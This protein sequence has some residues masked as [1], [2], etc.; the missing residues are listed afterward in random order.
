VTV[1]TVVERAQAVGWARCGVKR[2]G[3]PWHLIEVDTLGDPRP[4]R[5]WTPCYG[6]PATE[7]APP[8]DAR[9]CRECL[10]HL[11]TAERKANVA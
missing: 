6:R 10:I 11:A 2:A 9:W 3:G 1:Q 8:P 5:G 4:P 7:C